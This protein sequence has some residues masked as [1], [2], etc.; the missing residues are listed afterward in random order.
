M[1]EPGKL[2]LTDQ[3]IGGFVAK[4]EAWPGI[5]AAF[6]RL[7]SESLALPQF[8]RVEAIG[9]VSWLLDG[10]TC[11]LGHEQQIQP[12]PNESPAQAEDLQVRQNPSSSHR[13]ATEL[14]Q[15]KLQQFELQQFTELQQ[16][17]LEQFTELQ[18]FKLEQ[19]AEL[20]QLELIQLQQQ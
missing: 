17:E 18:Q 19:F 10:W 20:Q 4:L 14:Q 5:H 1:H 15:F 13:P 8:A 3:E 6:M 2:T 11:N 16:F 12:P 7:H 9:M